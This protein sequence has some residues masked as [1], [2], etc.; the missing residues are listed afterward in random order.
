MG[1]LNPWRGW[2][3]KSGGNRSARVAA[4]PNVFV[5]ITPHSTTTNGARGSLV[6]PVPTFLIHF[7][8]ITLRVAFTVVNV[9]DLFSVC[10]LCCRSYLLVCSYP[11]QHVGCG[12][13]LKYQFC[14]SDI[15]SGALC[16]TKCDD[17]PVRPPQSTSTTPKLGHVS[18][19]HFHLRS[20]A[21]ALVLLD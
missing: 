10:K 14:Q 11:S 21:F 7:G 12:S 8:G 16:P 5:P 18:P 6:A 13:P 1:T 17:N 9:R 2:A 15:I 4:Q 19:P 3:L 20:T